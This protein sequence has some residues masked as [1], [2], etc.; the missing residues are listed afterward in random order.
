MT[1]LDL[2]SNFQEEAEQFLKSKG[3]IQG[4]HLKNSWSNEKFDFRLFSNSFELK[5]QTGGVIVQIKQVHGLSELIRIF[6]TK[7]DKTQ[8]DFYQGVTNPVIGNY[9]ATFID[10]F[11]NIYDEKCN[12]LERVEVVTLDE[13]TKGTIR[14]VLKRYG[15]STTFNMTKSPTHTRSEKG[16]LKMPQRL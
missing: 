10:G 11:V 16:L 13:N 5:N 12:K 6:K 3:F 7:V 2:K 4:I 8:K 9:R 15:I 14:T 1:Y